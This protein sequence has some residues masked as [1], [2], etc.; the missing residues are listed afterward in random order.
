MYYY[1]H[2]Y[3]YILFPKIKYYNNDYES[4]IVLSILYTLLYFILYYLYNYLRGR[5]F[6]LFIV[7]LRK[8]T[9]V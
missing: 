7:L 9:E 4:S 6:H 8:V 3:I 1:T 5:C 2:T